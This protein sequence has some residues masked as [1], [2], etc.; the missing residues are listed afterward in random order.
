MQTSQRRLVLVVIG[1]TLL[2]QFVADAVQQA[3]Y[4]PQQG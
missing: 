1:L 3:L 4:Q 2:M